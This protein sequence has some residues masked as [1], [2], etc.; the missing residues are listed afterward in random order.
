MGASSSTRSLIM[1]CPG[2]PFILIMGMN[3]VTSFDVE[4]RRRLEVPRSTRD[5]R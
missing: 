2:V 1:I 3:L 4:S 5:L